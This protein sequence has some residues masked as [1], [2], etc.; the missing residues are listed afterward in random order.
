[1]NQI[2]ACVPAMKTVLW[3]PFQRWTGSLYSNYKTSR[4]G[5]SNDKSKVELT[6]QDPIVDGNGNEPGYRLNSMD[7]GKRS[8]STLEE[9]RYP[10]RLE[11]TLAKLPSTNFHA[12]DSKAT[13]PTSEVVSPS[14]LE[15]SKQTNIHISSMS[16]NEDLDDQEEKGTSALPSGGRP[17]AR[18]SNNAHYSPAI[19]PDWR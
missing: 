15:I 18:N 19:S 1:M 11:K 17:G 4:G 3:K 6:S 7:F 9:E 8:H 16:N 10:S 13:S 2:C 14:K 12:R 5:T